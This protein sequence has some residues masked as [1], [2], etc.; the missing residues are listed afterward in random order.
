MRS[1]ELGEKLPYRLKLSLPFVLQAL[2]DSLFGVSLRGDIEQVLVGR[3]VLHD[4]CG[5]SVYCEHHGTLAFLEVP[6]E[7]ARRAAEGG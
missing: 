2:P 6:H 5:F 1:F 3:S 4:G 7:L